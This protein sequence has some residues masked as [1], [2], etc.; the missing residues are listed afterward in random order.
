MAEQFDTYP[1]EGGT[2]SVTKDIDAVGTGAYLIRARWDGTWTLTIRRR[3]DQTDEHI[4]TF[5]NKRDAVRVLE[6]IIK[7]GEV[8]YVAGG[9]YSPSY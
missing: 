7:P 3:H 6:L 4:A 5:T 8:A 9:L 2:F 1:T